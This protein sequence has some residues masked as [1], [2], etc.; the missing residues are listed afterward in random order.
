MPLLTIHRP[1]LSH[2]L[3]ALSFFVACLSACGDDGGAGD[4]TTSTGTGTGG[5]PFTAS[6]GGGG[7]CVDVTVQEGC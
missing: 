1:Q 2:G 4:G 6:G 7:A 3:G 5:G